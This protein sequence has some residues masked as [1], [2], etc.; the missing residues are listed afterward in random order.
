MASAATPQIIGA[1]SSFEIFVHVP[2]ASTAQVLT[3]DSGTTRIWRSMTTFGLFG[4]AAANAVLVGSGLTLLEILGATDSTGSNPTVISSSGALTG[5]SLNNGAFL[6]VTSAQ[7]REVA[8]AANL[9]LTY[10]TGRLTMQNSGD[11]A[12]VS[13][14]RTRAIRPANN[15]TAATF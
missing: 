2:G 4:V 10:I 15:L 13:F 12:A 14:L 9:S 6:E 3:P 7:I 5:S 11:K 8:A 1:E